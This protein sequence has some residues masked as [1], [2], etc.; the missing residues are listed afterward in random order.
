MSGGVKRVPPERAQ[1]GVPIAENT[2][3]APCACAAAT[4]SSSAC[5]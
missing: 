1:A 4:A 5:M 2:I 3:L